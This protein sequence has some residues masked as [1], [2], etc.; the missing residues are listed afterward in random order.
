MDVFPGPALNAVL[1]SVSFVLL[2]LGYF[3]IRRKQIPAHRACM[4][5]ALAS[6]TFFLVSYLYYH[7]HHGSTRFTGEGLMR[8][9]YFTI[10]I[11]HT[12]LAAFL[13][14]LVFATATRAVRGQFERHKAVARWTLP[15]WLY[16]SLTGVMVYW[17]L[18][19]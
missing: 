18:Y 16:V 9:V 14:P 11:S 8:P 6:S 12:V 19:R 4:L 17:L 1:N 15:V 2:G 5:G 10:L 3:F 13:V 7:A